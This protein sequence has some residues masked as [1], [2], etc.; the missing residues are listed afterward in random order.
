MTNSNIQRKTSKSADSPVKAVILD[1]DNTLLDDPGYLAD[2]VGITFFPD[3]IESLKRLQKAGY[4]LVV[5]TNQSG[6]G[7]GYFNEETGLSVNLR[8]AGML[9]EKGVT[10]AAIYYC[11]HH[12][13]A[14][15]RCRKPETLMAER[16]AHDHN[17]D[18]GSSWMV[19]DTAKDVI[20]GV[21][22][23]LAPLMLMTGKTSEGDV[24]E[25][26]PVI[27]SMTDAVDLILH[28]ENS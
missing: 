25:G 18:R 12:P 19:G 5:V 9:K 20:M 15:C 6:I 10:L 21:R 11:R 16:A 8:M 26:I 27:K 17:I 2:P 14:G 13:D 7:R 4:L 23:G 1:R 24:P 28:G 3:V 22:A